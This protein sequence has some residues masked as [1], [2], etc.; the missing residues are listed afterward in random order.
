MKFLGL[1]YIASFFLC[2]TPDEAPQKPILQ[3][4]KT[5]HDFGD[6]KLDDG[7]KSH[8]FILTNV[9]DKPLII[10]TVISSCGCTT[11][12]WTKEPILPGKT[13]QVTATFL[14]NQG[15]YPFDKVLSVYISG[16]VEPYILHI[17][18]VVHQKAFTLNDTHPIVM[19]N[20][21]LRTKELELGQIKQGLTKSDSVEV[22]N[23]GK[24]PLFLTFKTT[25]P[26]LSVAVHPKRLDP[27]EVG[28]IVYTVNTLKKEEWGNIIYPIH[29]ITNDKENPLHV[30]TVKA[31]IK[32]NTA[33]MSKEQKEAA[34]IPKLDKSSSEFSARRSGDSVDVKFMLSNKGR[35]PLHIYKVDTNPEGVEVQIPQSIPAGDNAALFV[36]IPKTQGEGEVIYTIS[37]TT[38]SPSRPT[39]NV[40]VYGNLYK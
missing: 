24:N 6:F 2:G 7:E 15:P 29:I 16:I 14:N 31:S 1:L 3:F 32:L 8:T 13:G 30:L 36:H 34:P 4:D 37:L 11:P 17:R 26:N 35:S 28:Y 19:G 39:V 25:D 22:V 33:T 12:E 18:G 21:R 40:L 38:N 20:L 5:I 27:G 10:Q 23:T 9:S